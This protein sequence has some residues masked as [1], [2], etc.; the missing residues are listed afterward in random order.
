M[1]KYEVVLTIEVEAPDDATADDLATDL[2]DGANQVG[3]VSNVLIGPLVRH[4]APMTYRVRSVSRTPATHKRMAHYVPQEGDEGTVTSGVDHAIR[5]SLTSDPD[6][7]LL[8]SLV[9]TDPEES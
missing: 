9:P 2:I 7:Y 4:Q 1:K 8:V 3:Y 6:G 5:H